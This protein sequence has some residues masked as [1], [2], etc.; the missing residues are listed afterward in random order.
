MNN[1]YLDLY[2]IV[3]QYLFGGS[4]L[5]SKQYLVCTLVATLGSVFIIALP[6]AI[7]WRVIKIIMGGR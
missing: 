6:F 5:A 7:V 1:I 3:H 4:T 2:D